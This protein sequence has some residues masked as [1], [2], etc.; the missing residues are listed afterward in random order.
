MSAPSP[1]FRLTGAQVLRPDGFDAGP[2][3]LTDG[4]I[5]DGP[6][7]DVDLS[8]YLVLPGI[9]DLHGDAFERHIAPRNGVGFDT[10]LGLVSVDAEL[11]ANGVTTAYLA[12]SLSWE[13][14][15][16]GPAAA[17]A[18]IA[19]HAVHVPRADIRLQ[20]R[21]ETHFPEG[22][23]CLLEAVRSGAV[24]YVV[25]NNHVDQALALWARRPEVIAAWAG[26]SGRTAEA[27]MAIIAAAAACAP[28]VPGSL[29]RIAAAL[30]RAGVPFGSHDDGSAEARA[31]YDA[32]GAHVCEFP[33]TR[34]AA[35][36]AK[37][38]GNLVL[39]GAPNVVRGGS[40]SGNV[41]AVGLIA[42]GLCDVLVSDYYYPALPA[43]AW[44]LADRGELDFARAWRMVSS[45]S[46]DILGLTDRGELRP[47]ARADIVVLNPESRR[48]EATF[49]AG[50]PQ[51]MVGDVVARFLAL[52]GSAGTRA[53]DSR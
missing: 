44:A 30:S 15:R 32:L 42:D 21:Y 5:G 50:R 43:A 36:E 1:S 34:V 9:V 29:A 3:S 51:L 53:V 2:L 48:I 38:R 18:L 11:C 19:A 25:F 16:R 40:Q 28:E 26:E 13:G 33:T 52:S 31:G 14:G 10:A 8:G 45:N 49:V 47:G 24:G 46:A 41:A 39:M 37:A 12:Q 35:I 6:G 27:H 20:L 22:E 7:R 23:V 4:A 17:E